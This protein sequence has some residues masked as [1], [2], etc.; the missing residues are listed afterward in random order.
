LQALAIQ[1]AMGVGEIHDFLGEKHEEDDKGLLDEIH[2]TRRKSSVPRTDEIKANFNTSIRVKAMP[3]FSKSKKNFSMTKALPNP[4][5]QL[6]D[7]NSES[8]KS[9]KFSPSQPKLMTSK[10]GSHEKGVAGGG[11]DSGSGSFH[12]PV[13]VDP[14]L[15]AKKARASMIGSAM[16]SAEASTG[17]FKASTSPADF[18][19]S[20]RQS[21]SKVPTAAEFLQSFKNKK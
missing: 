6:L 20:F 21:Q 17:S 10:A 11:S 15:S 16:M 2:R 8:F 13:M 7:S 3:N 9:F 5:E 14:V 19:G 1:N 18:A 12:R 4:V